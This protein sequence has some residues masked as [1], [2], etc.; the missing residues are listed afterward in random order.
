MLRD[1][2]VEAVREGK[3]QVYPIK[4]IDEG[5]EVLTGIPAGGLSDTGNYPDGSV[6]AAVAQRLREMS[7]IVRKFNAKGDEPNKDEKEIKP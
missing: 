7:D 1:D 6:N 5:I 2:V 3:F 4:T